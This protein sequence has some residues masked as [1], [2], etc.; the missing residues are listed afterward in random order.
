MRAASCTRQT[1][2]LCN[3]G[4]EANDL[5]LR[6]SL[7]ARPGAKHVAVLAGAYHGHLEAL[8]GACAR[9]FRGEMR[10]GGEISVCIIEECIAKRALHFLEGPFPDWIRH[11]MHSPPAGM[12]PYKFWGV[13][14]TGKPDHVHVLPC[15]DP[16]RCVQ[17]GPC[18]LP[19]SIVLGGA[20]GA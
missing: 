3:S 9:M 13:G 1:V 8:I 6:V 7:K 17:M 18:Y 20:G 14:G 15:P 5:A 11:S 4:S 19:G 16:Y 10:F 2:Y 12:S